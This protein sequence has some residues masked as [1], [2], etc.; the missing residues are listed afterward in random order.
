MSPVTVEQSEK[1]VLNALADVRM[2]FL[3]ALESENGNIFEAFGKELHVDQAR[4]LL[5]GADG[6]PH[7]WTYRNGKRT[8]ST[9]TD[10]DRGMVSLYTGGNRFVPVETVFLAFTDIVGGKR[11]RNW[12]NIPGVLNLLVVEGTLHPERDLPIWV[13]AARMLDTKNEEDLHK[14]L[15][16]LSSDFDALHEELP[17]QVEAEFKLRPSN[18]KK[19]S[20]ASYE[21][22]LLSDVLPELKEQVETANTDEEKY[23]LFQSQEASL[24]QYVQKHIFARVAQAVEAAAGGYAVLYRF[25]KQ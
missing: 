6:A 1:T 7:R 19:Q 15:P 23:Q 3:Q 25:E 4:G 5:A 14:V 21:M 9:A 24:R 8:M 13:T 10:V 12:T 22:Q 17:A 2:Q 16:P 18:G 11:L 20:W